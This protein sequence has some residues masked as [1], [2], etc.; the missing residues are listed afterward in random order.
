MLDGAWTILRETTKFAQTQL[1]N[2][3]SDD[4]D[5]YDDEEASWLKLTWNMKIK[6]M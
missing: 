2:M 3:A 6:T 4:D 1:G 5:D